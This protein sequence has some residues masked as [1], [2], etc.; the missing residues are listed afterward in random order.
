MLHLE[1]LKV[2][3]LI[4]FMRNG[5]PLD[6][7]EYGLSGMTLGDTPITEMVNTAAVCDSEGNV[8]AIGGVLPNGVVWAL[9][10]YRVEKNPIVFL[11]YMKGLLKDTLKYRTHIYNYVWVKNPLHIK[12]LKFMGATFGK[13]IG[14]FQ[15][16]E[17]NRKE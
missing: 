13:Q 7:Q 6:I 17:F 1:T 15:Y 11:R 3:H 8:F 5:R 16:F 9:C 10:T 2:C 4:D 12:W 14:D